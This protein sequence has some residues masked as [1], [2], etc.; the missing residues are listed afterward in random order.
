[1][2]EL[3]LDRCPS[4]GSPKIRHKRGNIVRRRR[5]GEEVTIPKATYWECR[6]CGEQ[7]YTMADMRRNRRILE[8]R[9][10]AA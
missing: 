1:M 10:V 6:A 4:C 5:N 8:R 3:E 9:K 7:I 2:E